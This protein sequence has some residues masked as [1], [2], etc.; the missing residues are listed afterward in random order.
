M[1]IKTQLESIL[2]PVARLLPQSLKIPIG[3]WWYGKVSRHAPGANSTSSDSASTYARRVQQ[4]VSRFAEEEVINDLPPIFHYWSNTYLRQH[5]ESFGFSYPED[6]FARRIE[7]HARKLD[8]PL[9]I[10]S[11]GAGNCDSEMTIARLLIERG[12]DNFRFECL[13]ITQEMLR[14][15]ADLA[16]T[17]GLSAYFAFVQGDF[18]D[19][20]PA[21]RYDVVMANQSLHHVL[22]LESL[23]TAID[24]AIGNEGIFITS[25]MIGRNGHMRWPEALAIVQEFWQEL[26]ESYRY[27]RQLR[28]HEPE[29]GN[30]DCSV[31]GFEGI[32]AQD[33][34]P[35]AIQRFGF[36]F[37]FAYGNLVDPFIDRGFGP[38]FDPQRDGDREFIDRVHARDEAEMLAGRIKPTHILAVM[39][40]DRSATPQIWRH[41]TPAFCVRAPAAESACG[42]PDRFPGVP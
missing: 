35:L 11:I 33:I 40:R 8:R 12:I 32:R 10:I 1:T 39:R 9:R 30:W 37:F 38:H 2:R 29:F 5:L 26:P 27:N 42:Q 34:L 7:A 41:M 21:G 22:E 19:W 20:K 14:R 16:E 17:S 25:D 13:D 4:E 28:R 15:G 3:R 18:N 36:D 24:T 31:E 23:F 6:F